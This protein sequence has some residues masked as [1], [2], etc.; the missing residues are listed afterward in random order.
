[1]PAAPRSETCPRSRRG[2]RPSRQAWCRASRRIAAVGAADAVSGRGGRAR[3]GGRAP[4][5]ALAHGQRSRR[6]R[7]WG[8]VRARR[9]AEAPTACLRRQW[10]CDRRARQCGTTQPCPCLGGFSSSGIVTPWGGGMRREPTERR[11]ERRRKKAT[12][13][14]PREHSGRRTRSS[15]SSTRRR[16]LQ[17]VEAHEAGHRGTRKTCPRMASSTRHRPAARRRPARSRRT[18]GG[19]GDVAEVQVNG[20]FRDRRAAGGRRRGGCTP[21]RPRSANVKKRPIMR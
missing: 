18:H 2:S 21:F 11:R 3:R 10:A 8:R 4:A 7:A 5:V 14:G 13:R 19:H 17:T 9:P 12:E 6:A 16:L 20:G 15:R 1:M